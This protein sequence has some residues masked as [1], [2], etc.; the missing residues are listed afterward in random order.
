MPAGA[1]TRLQVGPF[2]SRAEA[3]AACARLKGQACFPVAAK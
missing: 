2:A 1:V 3:S